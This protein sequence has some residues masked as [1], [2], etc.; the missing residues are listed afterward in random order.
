MKALPPYINSLLRIVLII[1]CWAISSLIIGTCTAGAAANAAPDLEAIIS[2]ME[3]AQIT[4][5]AQQQS[6]T[7]T[8]DY[9]FF[10]G[11]SPEPASQVVVKVDF[12]P[13]STKNFT[14]QKAQGSERGEKIVRK[15]LEGEQAA[16]RDEVAVL[17][18]FLEPPPS[19]R[20]TAA[21]CS[22]ARARD[23]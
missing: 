2:R 1:C 20:G 4:I 15:V 19:S 11:E 18:A 21:G 10:N 14:I 6:Y 12:H 17:S 7:V 13:P 5:H 8:R 9:Q 22:F 16:A 3:Q 23:S